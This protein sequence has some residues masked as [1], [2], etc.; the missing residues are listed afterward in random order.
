MANK[1]NISGTGIGLFER[2]LM[3]QI[4]RRFVA[5]SSVLG[6][7]VAGR[8]IALLL[9][10][11]GGHSLPPDVFFELLFYGTLKAL[12]LLLPFCMMAATLATFVKLH[13]NNEAY[14]LYGAGIGYGK[15]YAVIVRFVVPLLIFLWVFLMHISPLLEARYQTLKSEG[16]QR[17]DTSV[18]T[19]G[20]FI[21][22]RDDLVLFIERI[23]SDGLHGIF[24]AEI[25]DN[26]LN[27]EIAHYGKQYLQGNRQLLQ[28]ENGRRYL[29]SPDGGRYRVL[30]Y[31][32][33]T[34]PLGKIKP[35]KVRDSSA[36]RDFFDLITSKFVGDDAELQWRISIPVAAF[37][38]TLLAFPLS[39]SA[40]RENHNLR[41]I[42]AVLFYVSYYGALVVVVRLISKG[43]WPV[44]P[45]VWP[46][47]LAVAL[48]GV[49]LF[50]SSAGKY[51]IKRKLRYKRAAK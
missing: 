37:I 18:I 36:E 6:V 50:Y 3:S 16:R 22:L 51:F 42:A 39:F 32:N 10:K 15:I 34:I 30:N 17:A 45:G 2:Y 29:D 47:H 38:L 27:V 40:P 25:G 9:D 26:A 12:P 13:K 7:L 28:L 14:A 19:S 20:R 23:D 46:I 48:F 8:L 1:L 33:H 5:I 4:F 44:F 43:G 35:R 41:I 31:D 11:I 49:L 24:T 21:T